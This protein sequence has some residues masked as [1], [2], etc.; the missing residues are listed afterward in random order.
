[1]KCNCGEDLTRL[2]NGL[3]ICESCR[4]VYVDSTETY[5]FA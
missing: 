3:L 4:S 5:H 2:K 1:M